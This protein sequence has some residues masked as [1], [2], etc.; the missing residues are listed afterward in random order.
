[1]CIS[2]RGFLLRMFF[3]FGSYTQ[4]TQ[5]IILNIWYR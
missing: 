3:L 5:R 2:S 4:K 1:M